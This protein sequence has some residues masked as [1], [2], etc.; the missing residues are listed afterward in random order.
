MRA[1]VVLEF[2]GKDTYISP[3]EIRKMSRSV[4][5]SRRIFLIKGG[6][7]ARNGWEDFSESFPV[8]SPEAARFLA[9]YYNM[10]LD[11][12]V[13]GVP[14]QQVMDF[15]ADNPFEYLP[16]DFYEATG[17]PVN[18]ALVLVRSSS[19][20]DENH[21]CVLGAHL[22]ENGN[23]LEPHLERKYKDLFSRIAAMS[24]LTIAMFDIREWETGV[25]PIMVAWVWRDPQKR[26]SPV[27]AWFVTDYDSQRKTVRCA[28][29]GRRDLETAS[30]WKQMEA[31]D[32]NIWLPENRQIWCNSLAP[33]AWR[34]GEQAKGTIFSSGKWKPLKKEKKKLVLNPV[35]AW[36]QRRKENKTTW[37][38]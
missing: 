8:D 25:S 32:T 14:V 1:D 7:N 13:L 4:L 6:R 5:H 10:L 20:S 18:P 30:D 21:N 11:M 36:K 27:R 29:F 16:R 17:H 37:S 24:M 12:N 38:S 31:Y 23:R 26:F 22:V 2:G 9:W 28:Q 35:R 33:G 3:D 19:N 15:L 34:D